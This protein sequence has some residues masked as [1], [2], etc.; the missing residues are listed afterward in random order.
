MVKSLVLNTNSELEII[1]KLVALLNRFLTA[2]Q[3]EYSSP[4]MLTK[5]SLQNGI[6]LDQLEIV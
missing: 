3:S 1:R 5:T 6:E 2:S 4:L